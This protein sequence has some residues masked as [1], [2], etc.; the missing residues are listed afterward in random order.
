[1]LSRRQREVPRVLWVGEH[2][3]H[4]CRPRLGQILAGDDLDAPL[5]RS[6]HVGR[7]ADRTALGLNHNR[8]R[9]LA[10]GDGEAD[11][12]GPLG[13][14][15]A[16]RFGVGPAWCTAQCG[17]SECCRCPRRSSRR[18]HPCGRCPRSAPHREPEPSE[19][20][21]VPHQEHGRGRRRQRGRRC[22]SVRRQTP[23]CAR[24]TARRTP[25][26]GQLWPDAWRRTRSSQLSGCPATFRRIC[27]RGHGAP[28][29]VASTD[30]AGTSAT[31]SAPGSEDTG[32]TA[33]PS[34][35]SGSC[36]AGR[37]PLPSATSVVQAGSKIQIGF[38][39]R[40]RW[41]GLAPRRLE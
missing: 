41:P 37:L 39:E 29:Q 6:E 1:M 11:G 24:S 13:G 12:V 31:H 14:G 7:S 34:F 33:L 9:V 32:D 2:E 21:G 30:G 10:L 28:C 17:P 40:W 4:T 26:R 22:R 20:Q 27:R 36:R 23:T 16:D 3:P 18:S 35:R 15:V 38:E 8:F 25:T 19:T 5:D